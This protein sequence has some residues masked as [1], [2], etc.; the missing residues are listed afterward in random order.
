MDKALLSTQMK[1]KVDSQENHPSGLH[2][3]TL[4]LGVNLTVLNPDFR[5]L[6]YKVW[7]FFVQANIQ[8]QLR[9]NKSGL[10][11]NIESGPHSSEYS[12]TIKHC[13][14]L[15][16]GGQGRHLEGSN[17]C[18]AQTS[19]HHM[20]FFFSLTNFFLNIQSINNNIF[21]FNFFFYQ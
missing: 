12:S 1:V 14:G 18:L 6:T 11:L 10:F 2:P 17:H 20:D 8:M 3:R 16:V 7:L 5:C 4:F 21:F 9:S 19:C 13:V 15:S